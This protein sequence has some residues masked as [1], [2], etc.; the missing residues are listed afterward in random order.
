MKK[1]VIL[2]FGIILLSGCSKEKRYEKILKEY[3]KIYYETY[4]IGAEN[5]TQAEVSIG[6]LKKANEYGS[7]F[8]LNKLDKCDDE[9]IVILTLSEKK[10]I[11]SYEFD[12]KCN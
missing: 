5:Q 8:D 3:T 1:I 4:M 2:F 7:N 9:T 10:D 11:V 12:L 6:M